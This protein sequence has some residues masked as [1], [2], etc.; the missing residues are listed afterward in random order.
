MNLQQL[1]DYFRQLPSST[2]IAVI[3]GVLIIIVGITLYPAAG[4]NL[5]TFLLGLKMLVGR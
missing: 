2:Q 3:V 1:L 4:T 5:V